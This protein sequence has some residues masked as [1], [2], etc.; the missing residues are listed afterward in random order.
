MKPCRI[1]ILL[2]I[3]LAIWGVSIRPSAATAS[4]VIQNDSMWIDS[5]GYLHIVG[6]VKNTGNLWLRFVKITGTLRDGGGGV[7]DVTITYALLHY[8]PP[9]N[10]APFDLLEVDTAKSAQV[11]SYSLAVEYQEVAA[12]SQKLIVLN[13]SHSTDAMGWLEVVGE[14]ENQGDIPSTY[15]QVTV[16][17]Y[18]TNGKVI[19]VGFTYTSPSEIPVG[20]RCG[21]KLYV[22]DSERSYRV[23]RY[24]LTAESEN[25]GYTSVSPG[26]TITT[27][28][29]Q[30]TTTPVTCLIADHLVINEVELNPVGNDTANEWV[31]LYNPTTAA[32]DLT[33]WAIKN[34]PAENQVTVAISPATI[35]PNGYHNV[36]YP[37]QWLDNNNETLVLL[38]SSQQE[39][40]RTPW[41]NDTMYGDLEGYSWQ[42]Y[43]DGCDH[44]AFA[45]STSMTVNVPELFSPVAAAATALFVTVF[46]VRRKKAL[47]KSR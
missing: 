32:I 29:Q 15:T 22:V 36:S 38:D 17:F 27:T 6:E 28:T 23:A 43:P 10:V 33:G 37:M 20:G 1:A 47:P 12:L 5:L 34:R 31:E 9:D 24:S 42:R 3:V 19:Y 39:V 46:F 41:L 21:F 2:I 8:L 14:V 26:T 4:A 40:D 45:P 7:V 35:S 16:T 44:W 18:D 13:V 30:Q 25:S 11:Q